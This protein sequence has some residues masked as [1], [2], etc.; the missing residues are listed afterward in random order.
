MVDADQIPPLQRLLNLLYRNLDG[1]TEDLA[2]VVEQFQPQNGYTTC[3]WHNL[4]TCKILY[5]RDG[6]LAQAKQ[7]FSVPYPPEL[8]QNIVRRNWKLL[9]AG[10]PAYEKQIQKA[11]RAGR[12]DL[13]CHSSSPNVQLALQ[14]EYS[15]L[16]I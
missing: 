8:R 13:S 7:R 12:F 2:R 11:V 6:R 16:Y 4:R 14:F 9:R 1:F 3:M 15:T 5:D 10:M